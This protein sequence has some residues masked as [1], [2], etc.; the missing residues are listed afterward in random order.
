ML[1][2][3]M[4]LHTSK[5]DVTPISKWDDL[6]RLTIQIYLPFILTTRCQISKDLERAQVFKSRGVG[7]QLFCFLSDLWLVAHPY[8]VILYP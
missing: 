6:I 2:R 4:Y 1:L 5:L 8:R 7:F 3:S